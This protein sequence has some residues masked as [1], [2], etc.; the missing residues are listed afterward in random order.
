MRQ[1]QGDYIAYRLLQDGQFVF[2][3]RKDVFKLEEFR[4]GIAIKSRS[5]YISL[6]SHLLSRY[7]KKKLYNNSSS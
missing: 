2:G 5:K 4:R 7:L 6:T 1:R 3:R